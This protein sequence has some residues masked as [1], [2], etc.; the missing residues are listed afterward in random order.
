VKHSIPLPP[1]GCWSA[2]ASPNVTEGT[3]FA[4]QMVAYGE[5][6]AAAAVA[7]ERERCANLA[8]EYATWG[9]SNFA[10]WFEKLAAEIRA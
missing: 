10:V 8:D 4:E 2:Y 1:A 6:C 9:G 3:F 7:L 5:A